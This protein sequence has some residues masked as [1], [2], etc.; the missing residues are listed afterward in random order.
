MAEKTLSVKLSLNDK[1]F[2]S[3]LRKSTRSIQRFGK[4]MQGFGDTMTRNITLP[5]VGL[6]A[7]AVK[8]ASDFE[9]T[10]SKFNTVFKDI[11][12]NAQAASKELSDSFGLSSRASMQLLSDTGDLLTG[13]GFTQEEALKLS[14]EVNKLA[15]DLASFTNVE[16]GAEAASKALTK[17]LLG[18][19]ESIKQL[20]IAITEADLKSFAAEQGLV[21]K[22]LGRVEKATLT[23][24]LAL[25]QS[26]NAVGDFARTSDGFAN[27]LRILKAELEDVAVQL[28]VEILPLAK[29]LVSGLRDLAK[30]TSKF[31]SEQRTAALQVAGF[32]AVLGPI[33]TVAGKMITAFSK[34]RLFFLGSLLPA[35]INIGKALVTLTPQ[36]K[37]IAGVVIAAQF[38][39]TYWNDLTT[40][41]DNVKTSVEGLLEKL[42]LLKKEEDIA[43]DFSI[44][45]QSGQVFSIEELRKRTA[46]MKGVKIVPKAAPKQMSQEERE[47]RA[48]MAKGKAEAASF[49]FVD[50]IKLSRVELEKIPETL[51]TIA[52]IE[53]SGLES[54]NEAFFSF[55]EEFTATLMNTL[56]EISTII[57]SVSNLF[58]QMHQKQLTELELVRK[59]EVDN[60]MAMAISE[61][62]KNKMILKSDEKFEKKKAELERK[63]ARRAKAV[64]IFEAI[65]NTAAAV[66]KS[67]PNLPLAIAT[68]ALGA[69]QI[70]TIA[71][72]PLPAFAD[73]GIVSGPTV[74]LMGEYA[75]A[76]TNPEVIAPLNRLKKLIGG[77]TVQVQGMISGEDIFLSND[78]YSRRKNSY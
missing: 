19:R 51:K 73:G 41:F 36:G 47:G 31:S 26:Q 68:G 60:I 5:V 48:R 4:K 30:F 25:Q 77:Q 71:S 50:S 24:Q 20:G 49:Q 38:I 44:Q 33:I 66:V 9:E 55:S 12:D 37:I 13:F 15:V 63:R 67:L 65:V 78:R 35:L 72:T 56:T 74:G 42:G 58:S 52:D 43:L 11:S 70:G 29:D 75:G 1:Q 57:G 53:P 14:K 59:T 76:N 21:F 16:G 46:A 8:L 28:G 17:A 45:D 27:Q 6:G 34:L 7:A 40:V 23:Y 64:A 18:E 10:Q 2:Q 3:A 61:E 32:A 69:V 62:E 39:Y 22:E 54:F